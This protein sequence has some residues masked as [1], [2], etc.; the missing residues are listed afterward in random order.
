MEH[1]L[2]VLCHLAAAKAHAT[3]RQLPAGASSDTEAMEGFREATG[4]RVTGCHGNCLYVEKS[5]ET[6]TI[7]LTNFVLQLSL[8]SAV[9]DQVIIINKH[10][11]ILV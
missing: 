10:F 4:P 7:F 6:V 9:I 8:K 1:S 3:T 5:C 11:G 2:P